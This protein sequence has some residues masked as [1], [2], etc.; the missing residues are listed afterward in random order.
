MLQCILQRRLYCT[1]TYR[2]S[3]FLCPSTDVIITSSHHHISRH[4]HISVPLLP[5]SADRPLP[6]QPLARTEKRPCDTVKP[7]DGDINV[8]CE[9]TTRHRSLLTT[10]YCDIGGC[11]T[12][13]SHCSAR[14]SSDVTE[15]LMLEDRACGEVE[16]VDCGCREYAGELGL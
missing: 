15:R 3:V 16:R 2:T 5:A 13:W 4:Q 7:I 10:K 9:Q 1:S 11:W 14:W 8:L 6:G 12:I